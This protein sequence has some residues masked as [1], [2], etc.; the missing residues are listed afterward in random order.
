MTTTDNIP[1]PDSFPNQIGQFR[2]D[3]IFAQGGMSTIYLATVPT[4]GEHILVKV[5]R[6]RFS[7]RP[8]LVQQFLNEGK[9]ISIADHPN[10]VKLYE[11]GTWE[12]G[13]Y[14]A[15]ELVNGTSLRKILKHSPLPL[16]RAL[17]VLLQICY[18]LSHLHSHGIVHGDLKPENILVTDQNQVK[19]ID[20]G[21]AK[22]LS[23]PEPLKG[24][25][26]FIGT[27]VYMSP[28]AQ[29]NPQN[30]SVQSDIYSLGIIAY[31]LV[32]GKITHGRVI[33]AQAPKGMQKILTKAL[34]PNPNDRYKCMEELIHDISQYI[35]SGEL[36][37]DRQGAD[38]FFDLFEQLEIKQKSL[39]QPLIPTENYLG[40]TLSY[41]VGLHSLYFRTLSLHG[42]RA[43]VIAEGLTKGAQGVFD[44]CCLHTVFETVTSEFPDLP[45]QSLVKKIFSCAAAQRL[46]FS[47]A[48]LVISPKKKQ[49]LWHENGWGMLFL[50]SQ[51]TTRKVPPTVERYQDQDRFTIVG[52]TTPT[53]LEFSASPLAPLDVV[54]VEAIQTARSLPPQTQTDSML[55]KLRLRGDCVLSDHPLCIVAEDV[56][57]A[58]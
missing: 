44:T 42:E 53:I 4:T 37:K 43:T 11:Y 26:H 33:L 50:S 7:S 14:I 2:I 1:S 18:S 28:E 34:Q 45:V 5:L 9:I 51:G 48:Y 54:L 3:G 55:Q 52:C 10:I 58:N 24:A 21:I 27:P 49:F 47:Y 15:M 23:S 41:G 25:P 38:Y 19:V 22:I 12:R 56:L 30:C 35:H 29:L 17:D 46:H 32:L 8:A 36:Q 13:V 20:F 6:P 16:K 39:I 57:A 31:E 40:V